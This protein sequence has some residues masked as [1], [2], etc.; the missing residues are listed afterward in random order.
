MIY[1]AS[2]KFGMTLG[3][4]APLRE[5]DRV[6]Q[7]MKSREKHKFSSNDSDCEDFVRFEPLP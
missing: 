7:L 1:P 4:L 6:L 3:E 2:E 5:V